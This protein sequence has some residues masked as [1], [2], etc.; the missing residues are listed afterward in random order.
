MS[1][2]TMKDVVEDKTYIFRIGDRGMYVYFEGV[3]S[4]VRFD[5]DI[6][7]IPF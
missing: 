6:H 1:L 7:T 4:G 3:G 2:K 5:D